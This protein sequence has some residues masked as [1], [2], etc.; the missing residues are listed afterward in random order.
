MTKRRIITVSLVFLL[1]AVGVWFYAYS[2]LQPGEP[3]NYRGKIRLT[4]MTIEEAKHIKHKFR[5]VR[6]KRSYLKST[7]KTSSR[8]VGTC[9]NYTSHDGFGHKLLM[10][11][12]EA[13]VQVR[14]CNK[15]SNH[16]QIAIAKVTTIRA[17]T[18]GMLNPWRYDGATVMS[19]RYWDAQAYSEIGRKV[20]YLKFTQHIGPLD[21]QHKT[22]YFD[23]RMNALH[24]WFK[25]HVDVGEQASGYM[26][27]W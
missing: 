5:I 1:I 17:D 15:R 3:D 13:W 27:S 18:A 21:I 12:V 16:T 25:G 26:P 9:R 24:L 7:P 22:V 8:R 10:N 4:S 11:V 20:V 19:E 14:W 6:V 2:S 23:L